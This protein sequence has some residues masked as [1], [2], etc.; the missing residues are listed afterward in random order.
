[1]NV[2]FDR[3]LK[4]AVLLFAVHLTSLSMYRLIASIFQTQVASMTVGSFAILLVLLF[5]GFIISHCKFFN[6]SY[7][8]D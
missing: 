5:G 8:K 3:F 6:H 7:L 4:Q 2:L 1:M